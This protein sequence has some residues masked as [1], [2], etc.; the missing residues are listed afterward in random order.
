M[1]DGKLNVVW[2]FRVEPMDE[3]EAEELKREAAEWDEW[4]SDQPH[5]KRVIQ[6]LNDLSQDELYYIERVVFRAEEKC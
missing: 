2:H 1:I 4:I 3:A 5:I 6:E